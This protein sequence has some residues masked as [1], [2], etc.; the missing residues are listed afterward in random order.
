MTGP[1]SL[2]DE[3]GLKSIPKI[4]LSSGKVCCYLVIY[5]ALNATVCL[6]MDG[7]NFSL[8]FKN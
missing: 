6:L 8:L 1:K 5:R 4:F 7:N 3:I 2:D